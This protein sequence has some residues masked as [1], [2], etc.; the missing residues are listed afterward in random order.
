MRVHHLTIFQLTDNIGEYIPLIDVFSEYDGP[1]ELAKKGDNTKRV[2]KE[3]EAYGKKEQGIQD[4][5]RA[6]AD[7][8]MASL[9]STK[10]GTMD[11]YSAATYGSEVENI[12][13]TYDNL[14]AAAQRSLGARGF[15][16][17]PSGFGASTAANVANARGGALT[18]AFRS[19]LQDTLQHGLTAADYFQK[20]QS[21]YNPNAAYSGASSSFTNADQAAAQGW[22]TGIGA[23]TG[24]ASM[25]VPSGGFAKLLS[26]GGGGVPNQL[27]LGDFSNLQSPGFSAAPLGGG[28]GALTNKYAATGPAKFGNI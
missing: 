6:T 15:G 20:G 19:G 8:F 3:Q 17:A 2:G 26:G 4:T 7:P 22:R 13:R 1:V 25:F 12:G 18:G 10:P 28:F 23:A 16:N 27:P 24:L 14:A 21:L 9:I 11:P 5:Y